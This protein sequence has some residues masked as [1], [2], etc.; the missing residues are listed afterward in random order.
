[1]LGIG[2]IEKMALNRHLKTSSQYKR[3]WGLFD[4][5]LVLE[6][7]KEFCEDLEE[8]RSDKYY[9]LGNQGVKK[10]FGTS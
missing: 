10:T 6:I 5:I 1:M 4:H 9:S 2:N 3:K 7:L 8:P